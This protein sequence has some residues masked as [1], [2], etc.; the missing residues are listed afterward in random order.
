MIEAKE[1]GFHWRAQTWT[2]DVLRRTQAM[3]LSQVQCVGSPCFCNG[4]NYSSGYS[5]VYES[6]LEVWCNDQTKA[7]YPGVSKP[8]RQHCDM[9]HV[10]PHPSSSSMPDTP[11][12]R[13][14]GDLRLTNRREVWH[15]A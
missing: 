3:S 2:L 4:C 14:S 12:M 15:H 8:K 6:L 10:V 1:R 5:V 9:V 13:S 11:S 7:T